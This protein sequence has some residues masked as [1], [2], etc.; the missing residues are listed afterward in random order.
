MNLKYLEEIMKSKFFTFWFIFG[1]LLVNISLALSF[2]NGY[3]IPNF[4]QWEN[5]ILFVSQNSGYNLF[6]TNDGLNFD[7]YKLERYDANVT[8]QGH[9]VKL[10]ISGATLNEYS[11]SLPSTWRLAYI[12]GND[13]SKWVRDIS[14]YKE[15]TFNNIY[16][17]IDLKIKFQGDNP[18]YDFIVKPGGNPNDILIKFEGIKEIQTD[19]KTIRF[20]TRFGEVINGNLFAFQ[21]ENGIPAEVQCQFKKVGENL[22]SFD[23]GKYDET[24]DLII[25]PIVMMSYLGG[26]NNEQIVEMK[27]ISTGI[28][29]AT[30]WTESANFPTTPG[31]YDDNYNDLRDVFICKLNVQNAKREL[32]YCTFFGG[33]GTDYPV[34]MSID[35]QGNIYIGGTTNSTDFPLQNSLTQSIN[36]LYDIFLTKFTPDLQNLVYS[37]YGGGNKDDIAVGAQLTPDK[38]F[39]VSG[40]TE[41]TNL[42]VTGGAYQTKLKGRKDIFVLKVSSS[43][44]L[45]DY[46]TYIGGSDDDIPYAMAVTETGNIFLTGTTKSGDFPMVPYRTSQWGVLDSPYDRTFNGGWDAF[47]I[48][49]LG[50]GKLEYSTYFGGTADDIG[51][52]VTYTTDEKIIFSGITYK[53]TTNPSFPISQNAYQNTHKGNVETFVASLSNVITSSSQWGTTRRQDLLFSTYLGGS[54]N[55][56]PKTLGLFGNFIHI[57]GTTNS[58]NFP[59]VN[60]PTGKKIGKY[61]IYYVKMTTDGSSVSY[62]DIYGTLDDD[63]ASA[64]VMTS[65]GDYYIAGVTNSKNL[66]QIN[67]IVGSGYSGGNDI[68]LLKYSSGDLKI[69]YPIGNEKICPNSNINIKWSSETFTATDTFNIEFKTNLNPEW[70]ELA[71]NVKGLSYNWF[72]PPT[73]FADSVW[74]R[75]SHK[76]GIVATSTI[77]FRIYELPSILESKSIPENPKVCEGD[78]I[79]LSVKARG[80]NIKYQWLFN[81]SQIQGATDTIYV[82]RKVDQSKKGKYKAVVSGPCPVTVETPE[83]NVDFVP[84]TKILAHSSDTT[85]KKGEKLSLYATAKGEDIKYQ[86]YKDGQK[87]LGAT[88]NTY[89]ISNVSILDAGHYLC[90]ITGTCGTDSTPEINVTIDTVIVSVENQIENGYKFYLLN[91]VLTIEIPINKSQQI[92]SATLYNS[93]GQLLNSATYEI[94]VLS[95]RIILNLSTLS[96]GIYFVQI[97]DGI[98]TIR[99]PISLVR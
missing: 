68:L 26:S 93:L 17:K 66:T 11:S 81:G 2:T 53:E 7:Y 83:F 88:E 99:I 41:S 23:I 91:D 24:K 21:S 44:Q 15:I 46:C 49:I 20:Y 5:R 33:N 51:L 28:L 10:E 78:S 60:N 96:T 30:G 62:S 79:I 71:S 98:K 48:K 39:I 85:V 59:I 90:K 89:S 45:I 92:H 84:S 47:C 82:I 69:D 86:W 29:L 19:N 37:T 14:G 12:K 80:S 70:S 36:G 40:Y 50:E 32:L 27:E 38:G 43:G 95:N 16:P 31:A 13:P 18:R 9:L 56:N 74:V 87:I 34:G 6:I 25:D 54:S 73:F 57:L 42:P 52:A 94:E 4:G 35:D 22:I 75:I 1:L 61:D 76:R 55:D 3:Y 58:T 63:S 72:I 65:V 67:P 8:K 77:P 97:N 64:M